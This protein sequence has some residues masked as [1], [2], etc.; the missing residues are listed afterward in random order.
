VLPATQRAVL[1]LH[2]VLDWPSRDVAALLDT[3]VAG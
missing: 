1:I 2:D 3:T